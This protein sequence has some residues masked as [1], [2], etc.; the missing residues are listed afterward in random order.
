VSTVVTALEWPRVFWMSLGS[1]PA[2][3]SCSPLHAADRPVGSARYG[4]ARALTDPTARGGLLT[5]GHSL[6]YELVMVELRTALSDLDHV[7]ADAPEPVTL[8]VTQELAA[9]ACDLQAELAEYTANVK[10]AV[11]IQRAPGRTIF[12]S[13]LTT[14]A[15]ANW[16]HRPANA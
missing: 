14:V 7:L 1:T 10:P 13:S 3:P 11:A 8:A 12:R 9:E 4:Q 6:W 5:G 2:A 15:W 16:P